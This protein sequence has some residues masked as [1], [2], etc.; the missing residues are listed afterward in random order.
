MSVCALTGDLAL[1]LVGRVCMS[2]CVAGKCCLLLT[3]QLGLRG[4]PLALVF[5]ISFCLVAHTI[6][7]RWNQRANQLNISVK[8]GNGINQRKKLKMQI[9]KYGT[10]TMEPTVCPSN[11][12][13]QHPTL[14]FTAIMVTLE[15]QS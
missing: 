11:L 10:R 13:A 12:L 8:K 15:T 1:G 5:E 4:A 6:I 3:I 9:L 14:L 7:S 2:V